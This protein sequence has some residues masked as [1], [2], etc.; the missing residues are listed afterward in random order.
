MVARKED[1]GR[2]NEGVGSKK[3]KEDVFGVGWRY[4]GMPFLGSG[5]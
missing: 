3:E 2:R 4:T 5:K 1:K